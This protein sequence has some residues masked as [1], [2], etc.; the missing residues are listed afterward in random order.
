MKNKSRVIVLF[1]ISILVILIGCTP[2]EINTSD[3]LILIE[4][5]DFHILGTFGQIQVF[6]ESEDLGTDAIAKAFNRVREIEYKMSTSIKNS[7]IYLLNKNAGV[8][9]VS[10]D[11]ETLYVIEKGID[12][13]ELTDGNFN[14]AIGSLINLWGIGKDNPKVPPKEKILEAMENTNIESISIKDESVFINDSNVRLDLG[15]IAKGYAVDEAIRVLKE[16]GITSGLVNFGG[17]VYAL[18]NRDDGKAWTVGI[19]DPEDDSSWILSVPVTDK[20]IVSS[21]DYERYFI[22]EG[23]RYHHILDPKTGYPARNE[24][25]SV[26]IISE[27]SIDA[28]V[29][30]TAIY[31]MGLDKGMNLIESLNGVEGIIIT[32]DRDIYISKGIKEDVGIRS[33]SHKVREF[34]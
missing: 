32:D 1:L 33:N 14:I 11:K 7:D 26:T 22:E 12:H 3:D 20:S 27:F 8:E 25:R 34:Y 2:N 16:S 29:L 17:D 6:A 30:S 13:Y 28:D 9:S 24:L 4:D 10:V 5:I 19:Q 18:G 23:E 21:G 31:I 15:G